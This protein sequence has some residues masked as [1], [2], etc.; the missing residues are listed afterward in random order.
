MANPRQRR[1]ARSGS[2]S[3]VKQSRRAKKNLRKH[4]AIKGPKALQ[5]A[6]DKKK[7][8][9]QNYEA[10]GLAH[11]LNPVAQGGTEKILVAPNS[12]PN[13]TSTLVSQ[14]KP[15]PQGRGRIIRDE[16]G[17]VIGIELPEEPEAPVVSQKGKGGVTWGEAMDDS[18]EEAEKMI[19]PE[20]LSWVK[21]G[22]VTSKEEPVQSGLGIN[23][24]KTGKEVV[25]ALE[26]L[27]ASGVKTQ[28]HAS[29]HEVVWLKELVAAHGTDI[30]AMA[31]DLK[32]NVWQKTPGE[33]KR[34]IDKAGG[35]E[36]LKAA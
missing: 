25:G 35:F 14:P 32:R 20:A 36:K 19:S 29:M 26:K 34:A 18:D 17:T 8:V 4:P 3:A 6:W 10:M 12:E 7:T 23:Q 24:K 9:K 30:A 33:L 31:H 15:I 28:R 2:H 13:T 21:I 16:N 5:D 22:K 11:S 27:S 1:K